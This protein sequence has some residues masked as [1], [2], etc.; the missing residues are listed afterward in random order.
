MFRPRPDE[1]APRVTGKKHAAGE[2]YQSGIKNT[3]Q[4]IKESSKLWHRSDP[5]IEPARL[6]S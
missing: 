1:I 3:I 4:N 2:K 6:K 5:A